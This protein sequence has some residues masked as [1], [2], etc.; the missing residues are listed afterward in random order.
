VLP[1]LWD[2][3]RINGRYS[4]LEPMGICIPESERTGYGVGTFVA[5]KHVIAEVVINKIEFEIQANAVTSI[6]EGIDGRSS[7]IDRVGAIISKLE[8]LAA[9]IEGQFNQECEVYMPGNGMLMFN[10]TL[11]LEDQCTDALQEALN[12]GWRIIAACPQPDQ[13]RPDYILGRYNPKVMEEI[14]ENTH[15]QYNGAKRSVE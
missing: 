8:D 7:A 9:G 14:I 13:R 3:A 4:K 11:L 12:K 2:D 5:S 1:Y 10:E 15:H 6:N